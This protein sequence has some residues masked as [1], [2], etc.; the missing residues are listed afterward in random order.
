MRKI[1]AIG[2]FNERTSDR[3][4]KKSHIS[5]T[6]AHTHTHTHTHSTNKS[7]TSVGLSCSSLFSLLSP[8]AA[9]PSSLQTPRIQQQQFSSYPV[10]FQMVW[11]ENQ[12]RIYIRKAHRQEVEEVNKLIKTFHWTYFVKAPLSLCVS[13]C[14]SVWK[15][16]AKPRFRTW[17]NSGRRKVNTNHSESSS[18]KT[19]EKSNWI[20]E[21]R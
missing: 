14:I 13:L 18:R 20:N 19:N 15:A 3:P 16:T 17:V 11:V 7:H 10:C 9:S 1:S 12:P 5:W 2:N 6:L 8:A 4:S 21:M